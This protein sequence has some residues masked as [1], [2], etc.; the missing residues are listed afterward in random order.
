MNKFR[1]GFEKSHP[2]RLAGFVGTLV[3]R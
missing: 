1:E 3:N 2:G